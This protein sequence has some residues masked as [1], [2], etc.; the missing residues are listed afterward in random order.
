MTASK[1]RS[2]RSVKP[3]I[4]VDSREPPNILADLRVKGMVAE[5]ATL[6]TGDYLWSTSLGKPILVERKTVS[7]LLSS[8]T[9]KQANGSSRAVNQIQRLSTYDGIALLAIEG[10]PSVTWDGKIENKGR[11]SS[12]T[13][14]GIDNFLLSAQNAGL[15]I[16]WA[17]AGHFADRLIGLV[18]YYEKEHHL[19]QT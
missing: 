4:W 19:W 3:Q 14:L 1:P 18:N 10:Y 13:Q 17:R 15:K 11:V 5:V 6:E 7:D 16:V 9:G 8:F 12:F 2:S